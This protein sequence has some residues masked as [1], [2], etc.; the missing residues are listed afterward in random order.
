MAS[1]RNETTT[2][3]NVI[4]IH[5]HDLGRHLTCY[6]ADGV[7]SPHL[8]E[9]AA[10]GIRF[11]DAHATAPL[12]SPARGSLFTGQYPHRNGL[13]G[14]AHHGFAYRP[15]TRTLPSLLGEQ[16][17]ETALFGMQHESSDPTSIGFDTV[18]VSDSRCGYVVDECVSWLRERA[19]DRPFFLTA[20][21]FET[22]RPYP[23][24]EY[25]PADPEALGVPDFLPDTPAVR[26][27][28]SGLLGSI[29]LADAAVGRL[30]QTVDELGLADDT[31]VVFTT[32]HGLAFPR[33]KSTL[34]AEGT[35]VAL[36]VRPPTR[37]GLDPRVYD[38]LFS[39]VD[40]TPTLLDLV[41]AGVP[42]DV[43]GE[44]HAPALLDGAR[45]PVR[46][47]VF[48]EKTYHDAYDPIRAVRTKRFSYIENY[49]DR[50]ALLLPLDIADSLSAQS[51]PREATTAPREAAE[52]Y[53]LNSDPRELNNLADDPAFRDVR[54]DLSARLTSWRES[55]GDVL[56]GESE[57]TAIAEEFMAVFFAKSQDTA[58]DE[59]AL[60]SRRPL[61]AER[62]LDGDLTV[63]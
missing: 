9:L 29:T 49:A 5:W 42:D 27:D 37:R 62:D 16:G 51:L 8:D 36:I 1:E 31:W 13:V 20:G 53:D 47:E 43:D 59:E 60:P 40:L 26:D 14:L 35:G 25:V 30:L 3:E 21:F 24:D 18:D 41:G 39:G 58:P 6:G 56:P 52:L 4:F 15:G 45:T 33:A 12:C 10:R 55:T 28:L 2:G 17:Y 19:D 44:S 50:P 48:T 38:D 23:E 63:R 61:G 7:Q 34:Y 57:G 54:D 22:H 32:D 46:S 11:S